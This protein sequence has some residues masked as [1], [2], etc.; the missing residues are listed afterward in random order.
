[1]LFSSPSDLE[2]FPTARLLLGSVLV[3][4]LLYSSCSFKS[5]GFFLCPKTEGFVPGPSVLSLPIAVL[6]VCVCVAGGGVHQEPEQEPPHPPTTQAG[7]MAS[8]SQVQRGLAQG[9]GGSAGAFEVLGEGPSGRGGSKGRG[10]PAVGLHLE[11]V[12]WALP[13]CPRSRPRV[14]RL[15][16][17]L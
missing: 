10:P 4:S 5:Q 14:T 11:Q 9:A 17:Q 3:L 12:L 15:Q 6:S 2:N 13:P 1:M 8:P 7:G 16:A